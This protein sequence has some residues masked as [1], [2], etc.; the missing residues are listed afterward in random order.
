MDELHTR[1]FMSKMVC[2]PCSTQKSKTAGVPTGRPSKAQK[3]TTTGVDHPF[4]FA[5]TDMYGPMPASTHT[6]QRHL[7]GFSCRKTN[8][9]KIYPM[10][11]TSEACAKTEEYMKW[12]TTMQKQTVQEINFDRPGGT[13]SPQGM[14]GPQ[15]VMTDSAARYKSDRHRDIASAASHGTCRVMHSSPC[16]LSDNSRVERSWQTCAQSA[17]CMRAACSPSE[18]FWLFSMLHAAKLMNVM[19][20]ASNQDD[21]SPCTEMCGKHP[22]KTQVAHPLKPFGCMAHACK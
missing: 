4:Q 16:R 1:Q 20:T 19:P 3:R 9:F 6:N 10:H 5:S 7:V 13:C 12:V 17:A 22:T 15:T 18:K 21:N 11:S 14:N 8:H 2:A